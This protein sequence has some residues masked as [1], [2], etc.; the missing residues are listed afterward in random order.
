LPNPKAQ[1]RS[2]SKSKVEFGC[3]IF[4]YLECLGKSGEGSAQTAAEYFA[5]VEEHIRDKTTLGDR[6][7]YRS[8]HEALPSLIYDL[9]D[10]ER[11]GFGRSKP[12]LRQQQDFDIRVSLFNSAQIIFKF[13]FPPDTWVATTQ[14]FWG[15]V[16]ALVLVKVSCPLPPPQSVSVLCSRGLG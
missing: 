5:G 12:S 1:N 16:M 14:K 6:L 13:F 8:V 7:A 2:T 9:L 4:A 11:Q 10:L 15:G 3:G